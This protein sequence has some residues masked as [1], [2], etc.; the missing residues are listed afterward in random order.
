MN[1]T[2]RL[3]DV[4]ALHH[5]RKRKAE[6]LLNLV[7]PTWKVVPCWPDSVVSSMAPRYPQSV[8]KTRKGRRWAGN[9]GFSPT[10]AHL[11]KTES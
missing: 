11:I 5:E 3:A 7:G 9:G 8:G 2:E 4:A 1:E 10:P 6:E